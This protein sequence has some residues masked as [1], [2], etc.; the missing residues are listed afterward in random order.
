MLPSIG[1]L[2]IF[3]VLM[4]RGRS[5]LPEAGATENPSGRFDRRRR[6]SNISFI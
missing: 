4:L 5:D 2:Y 3:I 1:R 6:S